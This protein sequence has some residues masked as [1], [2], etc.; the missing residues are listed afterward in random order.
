MYLLYIQDLQYSRVSRLGKKF[1]EWNSDLV[2]V[3]WNFISLVSD[4][5]SFYLGLRLNCSIYQLPTIISM[6]NQPVTIPT[7]NV[8]IQPPLIFPRSAADAMY[9]GFLSATS[10]QDCRVLKTKVF[11]TQWIPSLTNSLPTRDRELIHTLLTER[12]KCIHK[13]ES[14]PVTEKFQCGFVCIII[15]Y[16]SSF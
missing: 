10:G 7:E 12:L 1:L 14:K 5:S 15:I 4:E 13:Y 6:S 3:S 11:L 2:S 8:Q 16:I 9:R